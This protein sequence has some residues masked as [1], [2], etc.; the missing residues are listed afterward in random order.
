MFRERFNLAGQ[1]R[2]LL[3]EA[4]AGPAAPVASGGPFAVAWRNYLKSVFQ[5][6][7]MYKL[8]CKPDVIIYIAENKTLGGREDRGYEGEALGRKLAV[9]FMEHMRGTLVR[10]VN[11]EADGMQQD[12]LS[13]AELLQTVGGVAVPPDPAR[14]AA[15]TELLLEGMYEHLEIVR[16]TCTLEP[17]APESF[18]FNVDGDVNAEAALAMDLPVEHRTKM[19]LARCLQRNDSLEDEEPLQGAW[20]KSLHALRGRAANLLPAPAVP[21]GDAAPLAA[22]PAPAPAAGRGRGRGR[23]GTA[24]GRN[25]RGRASASS[26]MRIHV[27][28]GAHAKQQEQQHRC[29]CVCMAVIVHMFVYVCM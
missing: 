10:R 2:D 28:H 8:S 1:L 16:F 26:K 7:F 24:P 20:A 5:K 22:D 17:A 9:V 25:R 11:R 6:G 19:V 29:V 18:V 3:V 4:P 23:A 15:Q 13:I 21:A 12:L 27:P 14:T